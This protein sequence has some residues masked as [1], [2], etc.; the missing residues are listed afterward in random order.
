MA[1]VTGQL[2]EQ[3]EQEF[4]RLLDRLIAM[5]KQ[6]IEDM[7]K[8]SLEKTERDK[9]RKLENAFLA[10]GNP[11]FYNITG[12]CKNELETI[13][14]ERGIPFV[15]HI[16]DGKQYLFTASD[17]VQEISAIN[18]EINLAHSNYYQTAELKDMSN[19]IASIDSIKNKNI[20]TF[21]VSDMYELEELQRK[22]NN[23]CRG[24]MLG[25][26]MKPVEPGKE[27]AYKV[28]VYAK[29]E[30][31]LAELTEEDLENNTNSHDLCSAYLNHMFSLYG[32][33]SAYREISQREIL[34]DKAMDTLIIDLSKMIQENDGQKREEMFKNADKGYIGMDG[35]IHNLLSNKENIRTFDK[36]EFYVISMSEQ[37][38]LAEK[39]YLKI[40]PSGFTWNTVLPPKGSGEPTVIEKESYNASQE[41]YEMQ[42]KRYMDMIYDENIIT[43]A[44]ALKAYTHN[45][46]E[47]DDPYL[48]K[49]PMKEQ[50]MQRACDNTGKASPEELVK[51]EID[52][53]EAEIRE[54]HAERV[55]ALFPN[56]KTMDREIEAKKEFLKKEKYFNRAKNDLAI[57]IKKD[58]LKELRE[59]DIDIHD[60]ANCVE[61]FELYKQKCSEWLTAEKMH[62][63]REILHDRIEE[64]TYILSNIQAQIGGNCENIY[65]AIFES[66]MCNKDMLRDL[67]TKCQSIM[68]SSFSGRS[69]DEMYSNRISAFQDAIEE[70]IGK[71]EEEIKGLPHGCEKW[72]NAEETLQE[73]KTVNHDFDV[74]RNDY[75]YHCQ[76]TYA[77]SEEIEQTTT[78]RYED[79]KNLMEQRD[80]AVIEKAETK[81][82]RQQNDRNDELSED[83]HDKELSEDDYDDRE[84]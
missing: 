83:D 12:N 37:G 67:D 78:W 63:L 65:K 41:D 35:A 11:Y 2:A 25:Y 55:N 7:R 22:C 66:E 39:H 21:S 49:G 79:I 75:V 56:I 57:N 64:E 81:A 84:R 1:D 26:E 32:R 8:R 70:K 54:K 20:L 5:L 71:I 68:N 30:N 80:S 45:D 82:E 73:L 43:S 46:P 48:E 24:F 51:D 40:T 72:K 59:K 74:L 69:A 28:G 52:F 50:I 19:A 15:Y 53:A 77:L 62:D 60:S 4:K 27:Q 61:M 14:R 3:N 47:Y 36:N 29:P 44:E 18:K 17:F 58:T 9:Y 38:A 6:Y 33:G 42:L 34:H 31:I 76:E 16:I 10:G 23:I 13:L